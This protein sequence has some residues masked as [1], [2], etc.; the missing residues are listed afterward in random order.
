[1]TH[2]S[3]TDNEFTLY[4]DVIDTSSGPIYQISSLLDAC[5][6]TIHIQR[7][8]DDESIALARMIQGESE[9]QTGHIIFDMYFISDKVYIKAK[10]A[11]CYSGA[12]QL[13]YRA[14]RWHVQ[15]QFHD[16]MCE[17]REYLAQLTDWQ[18]ELKPNVWKNSQGEILATEVLEVDEFGKRKSTLR[19]NTN[20]DRVCK[21]F[22]LAVWIGRLWAVFRGVSLEAKRHIC[23]QVNN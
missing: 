3:P 7:L 23:R 22:L 8:H 17:K 2:Y 10:T 5:A 18:N 21:E 16:L 19:L 1:M 13:Y 6:S 14:R 12:A 11:G 15:H 4:G 9:V 20:D